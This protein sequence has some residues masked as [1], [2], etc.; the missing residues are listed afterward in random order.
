MKRLLKELGLQGLNCKQKAIVAYFVISLCTLCV[1]DETPICVLI[2]LVLN[3][4]NSARL[5]KKVP[6]PELEDNKQ[7]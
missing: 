6:L 1:S 5:I 4:A 2:L 7:E 3:F